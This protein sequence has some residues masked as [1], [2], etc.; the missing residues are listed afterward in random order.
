MLLTCRKLAAALRVAQ[1]ALLTRAA[2]RTGPPP[3]RRMR[4]RWNRAVQR[5]PVGRPVVRRSVTSMIGLPLTVGRASRRCERPAA[6]LPIG[7]GSALRGGRHRLLTT[8]RTGRPPRRSRTSPP[9]QLPHRP[10][11]RPGRLP[12]HRPPHRTTLE[13]TLPAATPRHER[14]AGGSNRP[15]NGRCVRWSRYGR[16]SCRLRW[17]CG[18]ARWPPRPLTIWPKPS[19]SSCSSGVTTYRR[20]R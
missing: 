11:R 7:A 12:R 5:P 13:E 19:A 1:P 14:T 15:W 16:H 2:D 8:M 10:P 18:P 3:R 4:R 6:R 20:R 17:R 9:H